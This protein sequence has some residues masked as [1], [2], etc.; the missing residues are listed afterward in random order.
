MPLQAGVR[1]GPYEIVSA[2]GSGGMGEVYKARDARLERTVAIKILPDW[3]ASDPQSRE[4]F[5]REAKIISQLDHPHIC[6]VYD[7]GEQALSPSA[8]P[9]RYLVMQYLEGETLAGRLEHG[10]LP[11]PEAVKVAIEI[12]S[13]LDAAHRAGIVHRDLKPGNIMVTKGVA[14]LLDFG[15]AKTRPVVSAASGSMLPTTPANIT[16]QGAIL[17]TF[18]YMAPEQLEGA[19]ADAR[20]DL[21]AFGAVLYEMVTGR[22]A[23]EGKSHA[24]LIAAIMSTPPRAMAVEHPAVP[25][26]VD[27]IVERCLAKDP[28]ARWQSAADL[29]FALQSLSGRPQTTA[30]APAA[31]GRSWWLAAL[32]ALFAATTV[33]LGIAAWRRPSAPAAVTQFVET[34]PAGYRFVNGP[35]FMR[36]S[37]DGRRLAYFTGGGG[38]HNQLWLRSLDSAV[39]Q[40]VPR[41]LST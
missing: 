8:P 33:A 2:L 10:T 3:L 41:E 34:P 13:A 27:R 25:P 28:D 31:V 12:G 1:L 14:K 40:R 16:A 21:F 11:V 23:F 29:T 26:L 38:G 39:A 7:V 36:L 9:V 32:A 22:K 17:G 15:L 19:D 6:A 4:R 5:D 20:T 35:G 24:S 18:Q 30:T 37:P